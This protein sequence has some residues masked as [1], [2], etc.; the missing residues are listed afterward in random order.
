MTSQAMRTRAGSTLLALLLAVIG[1]VGISS[2]PAA[3]APVG[4]PSVG[5]SAIKASEVGEADVT[6]AS[7]TC[8]WTR[9]GN[10]VDS[11]CTV[12]SGQVRQYAYCNGY[13]YIYS[14]WVGVGSWHIWTY[15]NGYT[16]GSWGYQ[17]AG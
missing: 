15:C 1:L 3:A 16:L 11:Y 14:P 12:Y 13:G 2:S 17:S 7:W 5:S 9:S 8:N 10:N 4:A 6:N